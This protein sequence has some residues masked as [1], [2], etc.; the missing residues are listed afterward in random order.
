MQKICLGVER[1]RGAIVLVV[2]GRVGISIAELWKFKLVDAVEKHRWSCEFDE[3]ALCNLVHFLQ[4]TDVSLEV[5][6]VGRARG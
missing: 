3:I 1:R 2:F 4:F 6:S 5:R